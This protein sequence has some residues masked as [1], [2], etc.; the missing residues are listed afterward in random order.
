MCS[1][2]FTEYVWGS[3]AG[4]WLHSWGCGQSCARWTATFHGAGSVCSSHLLMNYAKVV[5]RKLLIFVCE[6]YH[7]I[8][9]REPDI[10]AVACRVWLSA[11]VDFMVF[12]KENIRRFE[13]F[14]IWI[15]R[16]VMKVLWT[17]H[18]TNEEV[19]QMVEAEREIKDTL[20][21]R[22]KRWI[23]HILRHDS[24]LKTTLEG[25]IQGKKNC[26]RPRTMLLD[27]LLKT[28][29][30]TIGYEELKI[31]AQDRSRWRKRRW[32]PAIIGRIL[33]QQHIIYNVVNFCSIWCRLT[34]AVQE[35]VQLNKFL[36]VVID[37]INA[38][39]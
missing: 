2:Y 17:E 14:K 30:A 18:R 26:G 38:V 16:R 10:T 37:V 33:Q 13:A 35:I 22:Q 32:K 24:L 28:E 6:P 34:S 36:F 19:L 25:Q 3:H 29:E 8:A 31:L 39:S 20:R 21:S 11:L 7:I 27:W 1:R 9:W 4:G 5:L 15:W 12:Q 23:G